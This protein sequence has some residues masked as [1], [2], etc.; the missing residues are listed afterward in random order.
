[1]PD[2]PAERI[3]VIYVRPGKIPQIVEMEESLPAM[4]Q[5]VGGMI[6]EYMPF[7]SA[8]DKRIQDVA[9]I[10]NDEGKVRRMMPNRTIYGEDSERLDVI[11]GDFFLCYAPMESERF[12]SMPEDLQK[13]FYEKFYYPELFYE[14][15]SGIV[16][17]K[18]EPLKESMH[19]QQE[20]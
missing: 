1:M 9:L 18:Y 7:Y 13:V 8:E 5:M 17:R 16:G 12:L 10:C 3:T 6:E 2:E 11:C 4:Q 14:T 15:E 19:L 20:R